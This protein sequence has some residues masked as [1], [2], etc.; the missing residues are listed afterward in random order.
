MGR[1]SSRRCGFTLIELL[2]VVAIIGVL[3]A[4]LLPAISKA[5]EK[6]RQSDCENNMRQ[7]SMSL[8]MYRDDHDEKNIDWLSNLYPDYVQ[9]TNLYICKSDISR[10]KDGS[11]PDEPDEDIGDSYDE[12]DDNSNNPTPYYGRNGAIEGCSYLYEFSAAP[13]TSWDWAGYLGAGGD[14]VDRDGDPSVTTWGEVKIYQL[15][16][17]DVPNGNEAYDESSFPIIRCFHHY[18]E[19]AYRVIP[20]PDSLLDPETHYPMTI[21]AAYA[22]NIFRSTT[23]WEAPIREE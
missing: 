12:T 3:A 22:G 19:A 16:N 1:V 21:N 15:E 9:Y 10:G 20:P 18:A 2:V 4:L 23:L 5:R 11:K 7:F 6:A 8:I 17:G 13:C 14:A